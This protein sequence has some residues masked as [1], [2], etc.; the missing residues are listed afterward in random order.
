V[1]GA[2]ITPEPPEENA[3]PSVSRPGRNLMSGPTAPAGGQG[4]W[5]RGAGLARFVPPVAAARPPL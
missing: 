3:H 2:K 4:G 1:P 5:Y